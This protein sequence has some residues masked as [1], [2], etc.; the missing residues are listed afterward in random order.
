MPEQGPG[1]LTDA[2][3]TTTASKARPPALLR[4]LPLPSPGLPLASWDWF[5]EPISTTLDWGS[6]TSFVTPSTVLG[7]EA[8]VPFFWSQTDSVSR[9]TSEDLF[10]LSVGNPSKLK[11]KVAIHFSGPFLRDF[12]I[13]GEVGSRWGTLGPG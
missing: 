6:A 13:Q 3:G 5:P 1:E 12:L 7:G 9:L 4:D 10:R 2:T 11:R 8:S